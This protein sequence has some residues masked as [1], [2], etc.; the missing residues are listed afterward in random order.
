MCSLCHLP[1]PRVPCAIGSMCSLC[2]LP[3]PRVP[4]ARI[5]V[6]PVP[7]AR[8]QSAMCYKV[9]FPVPSARLC[10]PCARE[11]FHVPCVTH[12]RLNVPF[13]KYRVPGSVFHEICD[14]VC[15]LCSQCIHTYFQDCELSPPLSTI[16][17]TCGGGGLSHS[18]ASRGPGNSPPPSQ[19][20]AILH[21]S[22]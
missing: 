8:T 5:H 3:G 12:V 14:R 10:V 1:G 2:H 7:S 21:C 9:L 18:G 17:G 19:T 13:A 4:C 22:I 6:F 11:G 16:S 15:T 20:G